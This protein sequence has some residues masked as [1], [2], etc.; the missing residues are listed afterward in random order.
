MWGKFEKEIKNKV[1]N[2][3]AIQDYIL[4]IVFYER[5]MCFNFAYNFS[6]FRQETRKKLR[7]WLQT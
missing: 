4:K 6:N 2:I 5:L 3:K 7:N 1:N